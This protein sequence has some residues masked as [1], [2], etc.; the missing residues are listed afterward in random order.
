MISGTVIAHQAPGRAHL[1]VYFIGERPLLAQ[2]Q[3]AQDTQRA[4]LVDLL[5]SWYGDVLRAV[6]IEEACAMLQKTWLR[7]LGRR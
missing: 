1:T 3:A 5:V 7:T 6:S 2:A 4:E